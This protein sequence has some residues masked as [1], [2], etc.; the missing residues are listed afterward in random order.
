LWVIGSYLWGI[1]LF[2]GT[3]KLD[4]VSYSLGYNI[5]FLDTSFFHS[6]LG[7]NIVADPGL[8]S[9]VKKIIILIIILFLCRWTNPINICAGYVM[10]L[11]GSLLTML[12]VSFSNFVF[13][14]ESILYKLEILDH[15]TLERAVGLGALFC[16]I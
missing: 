3:S 15:T 11:I 4:E 8:S 12:V 14:F 10:A 16:L 9:T 2:Y 6:I 1:K 13:S 5:S 7:I